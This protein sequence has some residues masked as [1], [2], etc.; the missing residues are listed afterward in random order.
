MWISRAM[1]VCVC[2][3]GM[4]AVAGCGGNGMS[5][6]TSPSPDGQASVFTVGTDAPLPSVISC[7]VT[8]TGVT[9]YN[10]ATNVNVM[11]S[12]PQTI[13]FAKLSGLHQLMDLNAVPTGTYS[14]ATVTLSTVTIAYLNTGVTP[15]T[16]ST[17]NGT[18]SKS[19]VMVNF[20]QPFVLN[21]NDLVGLR[22][23]F[24][25]AK[26]LALDQNGQVTGAVNP[27][28][29]MALL[30]SDDSD[31][32]IDDFHAGVVGVTG[33][34]SFTVQ[35]P[36]GRQ[37]TVQADNNTVMDDPNDPVSQFTT[38]TIV[39]ISGQLDPVTKAIDASEIEV[40]S[41]DNFYVSGLLTSVRPPA[42]QAAT[43]ADLYVRSELPDLNAFQDGQIATFALNGSEQYRIG[44][45]NL[46]L[47]SL[48]FNNNA[49]A[50]G[51][52]V[53]LG[54][55]LSSSNG[56]E[57]LTVHRV[58]LRKQGQAGNWVVGS[59]NVQSGDSGSF[60]LNDQWTAGVLLPNPLIVMTT[61]A[62]RFSG[63]LTG[64]SGLSG[65]QP[66]RVRVVGF[67]LFDSVTAQPVMIANAVHEVTD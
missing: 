47:T 31:V 13:D 44:N 42:P 64:L 51:Q 15:P 66:I 22:M 29:H 39:S 23:E 60:Q 61:N 37:W 3:L 55:A 7:N 28:F 62:T 49:M 30:A 34:N 41:N 46:P 11:P 6:G 19:S 33:S 65:T 8:I 45:I 25:L 43:A 5:S 32:S 59:T 4:L 12:A 40:V 17:I 38:S 14:S 58:V 63:G 53:D 21:D 52:R 24:D 56:T 20:N 36:K 35:G 26:S 27:T 18:L 50:A 9:V 48:L 10:G 54:G 16:V 2:V 57:T 67:I 1:G